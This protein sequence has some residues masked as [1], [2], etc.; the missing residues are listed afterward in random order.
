MVD[1]GYMNQKLKGFYPTTTKLSAEILRE[2]E[3]VCGNWSDREFNEAVTKFRAED[4][5]SEF[6]PTAWALKKYG[7]TGKGDGMA[8]SRRLQE[9]FFQMVE[10]L[11]WQG[12]ISNAVNGNSGPDIKEYVITTGMPGMGEYEAFGD[13]AA[14]YFYRL[15]H[16]QD[17]ISACDFLVDKAPDSQQR[18]WWQA[19]KEYYESLGLERAQR[20]FPVLRWWL[21]PPAPFV[22]KPPKAMAGQVFK[23]IEAPKNINDKQ[24]EVRQQADLIKQERT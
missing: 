3:Q 24:N 1:V 17:P 18:E 9:T 14:E 16:E 11:G 19:R 6:C 22:R 23:Q 4:K 10:L 12:A 20:C 7:P 8:R 5:K 15:H 13:D 2:Y 21:F